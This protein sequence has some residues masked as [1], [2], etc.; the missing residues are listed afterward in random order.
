MMKMDKEE[1]KSIS[2][3]LSISEE[4]LEEVWNIREKLYPNWDDYARAFAASKDV[5][6]RFYLLFIDNLER[7][8][9]GNLERVV[10]K[11]QELDRI[12]KLLPQIVNEF[13]RTHDPTLMGRL[14]DLFYRLISDDPFAPES[15]RIPVWER[16]YPAPSPDA[17]KPDL[18]CVP[19]NDDERI[20]VSEGFCRRSYL[21]F[22][23]WLSCENNREW[24]VEAYLD[25]LTESGDGLVPCFIEKYAGVKGPVLL[26]DEFVRRYDGNILTYSQTTRKVEPSGGVGKKRKNVC[27]LADVLTTG[28][29]LSMAK[30]YVEYQSYTVKKIIVLAKEH[31]REKPPQ[32]PS[33]THFLYSAIPDPGKKRLLLKPVYDR[34]ELIGDIPVEMKSTTE[35]NKVQKQIQRDLKWWS[36]HASGNL[37]KYK[38]M[39]IGVGNGQ[40]VGAY[41]L[42]DLAGL[43][44]TKGVPIS[45]TA[46]V[47]EDKEYHAFDICNGGKEHCFW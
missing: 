12:N 29:G 44:Q 37:A 42:D 7:L 46:Y 30:K 18:V 39:W 28:N 25:K 8:K 19:T 43:A 10:V 27:I 15:I 22:D 24:A 14:D 45:F 33:D 16:A 2:E 21:N 47:E 20:I 5:E 41:S 3:R 31:I 38:G 4:P 32:S 6:E 36:E 26:R 34:R 35:A 23:L 17:G 40:V 13:N 11:K 9:R 1:L